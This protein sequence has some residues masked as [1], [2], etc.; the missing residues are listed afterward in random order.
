MLS[1]LVGRDEVLRHCDALLAD[2]MAARGRVLLLAGEA[3]IG[4][5]ALAREVVA[6]AEG[7]GAVA[8]WGACFEGGSLLPFGVWIDCLRHPPAAPFTTMAA[9][10][11]E[12]DLTEGDAG[13]DAQRQRLRLFR[14]VVA[15]VRTAAAE[16][17]QVL[18]LEDLHWADS[19]SLELLGAVVAATP[20][21]PVL[22]VATYR[23]EELDPAGTAL[24]AVGGGVERLLLD[25]LAENDVAR[26]LELVVGQRPPADEVRHVH[27]QTGGN[28]LFV[29]QVAR[30]PHSSAGDVPAPLRDVLGRRLARCSSGCDRVLGAA[31]VVGLEFE[32]GTVATILDTSTADVLDALADAS[33]AHVAIAVAGEPGRWQFV[34]D[35]IRAARYD[36]LSAGERRALHLQAME[37]LAARGA[38]PSVLVR[39]AALADLPAHD[40][41]TA[42]HEVA[43][44][45]EAL[46]RLAWFE[47][48]TL[49]ERAVRSAP[50]GDDGDELRGEAWLVLGDARL[51]AG[52]RAG[53]AEA[54]GAAAEVGRRR[55]A[56]ELVARAALGFSAG[57][58]GFEVELADQPQLGMLQEA[59]AALTT[60][61]PL[62]PLVLARLS[63]ALSL[64]ASDEHRLDL[65]D[66]AVGLARRH[67]DDRALAVALAA[68]CDAVAGPDHIA[69]RLGAASEIVALAQRCGDLAL[70]LLGRRLRVVAL[71][72]QRKLAA[73]DAEVAVFARTAQTL[74]DPFYGWY[75]S[76]W[77][78]MRAYANGDLDRATQLADAAAASGESAGSRN[79]SLLRHVLLG[80]VN[81]DR[82]ELDEAIGR[83][84]EMMGDFPFLGEIAQ[85]YSAYLAVRA[86]RPD[87]A[88]ASLALLGPEGL[89]G[90]PKDQEWLASIAQA[91]A[92][93]SQVGDRDMAAH[94]YALLAPY[95]G[96]GVF[97]GIAAADHGVTDRFL[98][99]AAG[100][101]GEIDAAV[102]HAEAA[103]AGV[104]GS[105]RL[106]VAHT[107]ADCARALLSTGDPA[108]RERAIELAREAG[109]SYEAM[110]LDSMAAETRSLSR[111]GPGA[112]QPAALVRE[113]LGWRFSF[114]GNAIRV[115]DAKGIADL[116]VMLA[117]PGTPIHVR[118]L[119]G[120]GGAA[121]AA[122]SAQP[123]LDELA[124]RQ[125][126]LRLRDLEEELD[127]ADRNNDPVAS[128]RLAAERDALVEQLAGAFGLGG[129]RR[130]VGSDADERLRKAVSAR[131]KAAIAHVEELHPVLG[132]H[133]R[134]SVRTGYWC[135][136]EPE[137]PVDWTVLTR[138]LPDLASR[139]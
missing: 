89:D 50:P 42:T 43:A 47:A 35:L 34:H 121:A 6:R 3:G 29:T 101:A 103:L 26:L 30:L 81:L 37:V 53:A 63:V 104:E 10:L 86:G 60:S 4:K 105:G 117:R 72:E 14:D 92:A 16:R 59:A 61:A 25:G 74:G 135:S 62:R 115:A 13:T 125:Y 129:R 91:A 32:V 5:T 122:M 23:H 96:I 31:S 70:E 136:Y 85:A 28:P 24:A 68:R 123:V 80:F 87:E 108:V 120:A 22:V 133:L 18:V 113:R 114:D 139:P 116:A 79:A 131:V 109:D 77:R 64:Q 2:A 36:S 73:F 93:A 41:R 27:R 111:R 11:D 67:G 82:G 112:E 107:R 83:Y 126:R 78:A 106:V 45:R 7:A 57:L 90:Y 66:E 56:P 15:C 137:R 69:D 58:G 46:R 98:T 33:A 20:A 51:R 49:G 65:A 12:G 97:D 8:R 54:F 44:A 119:Q 88:R 55:C 130:S 84:R 95:A 76:L 118:A 94:A 48:A 99:L 110:G 40:P 17:P 102:R 71:L 1:S 128:A 127:G 75:V 132:R 134:N 9:R 39:H 100:C 124:V 38:S 138:P 19:G 21:L 52:D